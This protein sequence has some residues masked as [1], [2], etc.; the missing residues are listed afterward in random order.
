LSDLTTLLSNLNKKKVNQE[1]MFSAITSWIEHN[2][3]G[4]EYH[5]PSLFVLIDLTQLSVEFVRDIASN[6]AL[7]GKNTNCLKS[8]LFSLA[9]SMIKSVSKESI[10][11]ESG[12]A[13]LSLGGNNQ[14]AVNEVLNISG[15]ANV[16]YPDLPVSFHHI[17]SV[18]IDNFIYCIGNGYCENVYRINLNDNVMEWLEMNSMYNSKHWQAATVFQNCILVSDK[19]A[20]EMYEIDTNKWTILQNLNTMRNG[21]A[22]VVCN[23]CLFAIGG[24]VNQSLKSVEKLSDLQG[25]WENAQSMNIARNRLAAVCLND[26]IY[27]IGGGSKGID[28]KGVVKSV[29]KFVPNINEWSFVSDMNTARWGHAAC[30]MDGKIYVIGGKDQYGMDISTIECYNPAIDCWSIVVHLQSI[31]NLVQHAVVVV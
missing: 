7:V 31:F 30:V 25:K 17:C 13:I 16:K 11:I 24:Y 15:T 3:E 8:L 4:R 5:F 26:T 20:V 21:H 12:S 23:D 6:H 2:E 22:L 19:N 1:S 18:K 10:S 29:E 28:E 27:A 9:S 14:S